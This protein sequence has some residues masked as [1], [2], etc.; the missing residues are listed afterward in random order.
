MT[1]V[2][3]AETT[4]EPGAPIPKDAVDPELIK[5]SRPRPKVGVITAA[6]LVFLSVFFLWRLNPDRRFSSA[7]DAPQKVH[8]SD[9]LAGKVASDASPS[10][11]E[12]PSSPSQPA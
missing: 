2:S 10:R 11:I 5:L 1:P 8:V 3:M 4:P 6:G 9:V 7:G 12:R